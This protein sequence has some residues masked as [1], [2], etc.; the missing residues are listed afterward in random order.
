MKLKPFV[1]KASVFHRWFCFVC[2]SFLWFCVRSVDTP[3][4][5]LPD[6]P[7]LEED[8]VDAQ[9]W[10]ETVEQHT[11]LSL[12]SREIDC[13]AVI[14]GK[15]QTQPCCFTQA[16]KKTIYKIKYKYLSTPIHKLLLLF[17]VS[18]RTNL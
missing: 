2:D 16:F 15:G 5:L 11:L 7:P 14:Y 8:V 13:Q 12:S 6:A 10:Q 17:M 1:Q 4:A 9:N 3:L 18:L